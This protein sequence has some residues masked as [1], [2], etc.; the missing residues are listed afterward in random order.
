[1]TT[2]RIYSRTSLFAV[3]ILGMI[4]CTEQAS[5][6]LSSPKLERAT[7]EKAYLQDYERTQ[8]PALGH[9]TPERLLTAMKTIRNQKLKKSVPG[10]TNE[11]WVERGPSNVGGRTRA[12]MF[13]PNDPT[14]KKVWAGGVTGGLWY[15]NDITSSASKWRAVDD[16]W[17]NLSITCIAADPNNS[18][19]FYVGTG[20]SFT[21]ASRGSGLWK[22]TDGGQSWNQVQGSAGFYYIN[23]IVVRDESGQSVIYAGVTGR[24]YAGSWHGAAE[25]GLQRSTDGGSSWTQVL[26]NIPGQSRPAAASDLELDA[27]NNLWVGTD[28]SPFGLT[29]RG[30][31]KI[32]RS[33]NGT[34]FQLS[35]SSTVTNGCGR[36]ELACAPGNSA[37]AYAIV[38]DVNTVHE[39]VRTTNSGSNW[40]NINE[41][42]DADNGIPAT[43]FTRGQA[44]YDLIAAVS[45][46]NENHLVVGGID[47]FH[48]TDGGNNWSQISKWSNNN[49]L[50]NLNCSKVHADHHQ[51]VFR[52]GSSNE[53]I[54]G[55]DGGLYYCSDLSS[56][57]SSNVVQP[58]NNN[59]NVTQFYA[60][61]MHPGE[62]EDFYLAG[63]QDNGTQ[64]FN[65]FGNGSTMEATGGDGAFCFVDQNEPDTVITSYVYNNYYL[66][67][68]G[69][70]T[71]TPLVDTNI[72]AFINPAA[73]DSEQNLLYSAVDASSIYL[74]RA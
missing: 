21:G 47:L 10:D 58:R 63:S 12:I 48:S 11:P 44:F 57:A 17:S 33:T 5:P 45:P 54:F 74:P 36:V 1:M 40:S 20:E 65:K 41:P 14:N 38:E 68:D 2:I 67:I 7:P 4:S 46:A 52:P 19:V 61:A 55:T 27:S 25:T 29:D 26:P 31:G 16:F 23:D 43:D 6:G 37:Y 62:G 8:D 50:A 69:G 51:V 3:F 56:A 60:A 42:A 70:E 28:A 66:S 24:Y 18:Q 49:N 59:Y 64:L 13:D 39:M 22:T 73:Y 32:Y 15:N 53:V 9:P 35:Y 71:F 30:G 72:G 34:S